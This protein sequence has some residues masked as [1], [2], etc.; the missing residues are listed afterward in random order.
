MNA[1][2]VGFRNHMR[3][4]AGLDADEENFYRGSSPPANGGRP[5]LRGHLPFLNASLGRCSQRGG[6]SKPAPS[7]GDPGHRK[8]V[9]AAALPAISISN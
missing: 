8:S 5:G 1:D 9:A 7:V 3:P 2:S 4:D 6:N